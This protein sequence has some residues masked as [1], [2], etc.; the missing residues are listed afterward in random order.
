MEEVQSRATPHFTPHQ[1]VNK[2]AGTYGFIDE[3]ND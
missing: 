1:R 2:S 3:S